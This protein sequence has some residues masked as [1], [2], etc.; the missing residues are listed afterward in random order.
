[1]APD[2]KEILTS[3]KVISAYLGCKTRTGQRWEKELGLPVH[4][5]SDYPRSRVYAYK[6]E[7]DEWIKG[8]IKI[9][10]KNRQKY[11]YFLIPLAA[12]I[13]IYFIWIMPSSSSQPYDFK[14]EGSELVALDKN[15][16]ELWCYDTGH[17]DLE[18]EKFY[19]DHFQAK[20]SSE[21]PG[22]LVS[23][24]LIMIQDI[25]NDNKKEV[26]FIPV[27][28]GSRLGSHLFC[29]SDRGKTKWVFK[30]TREMVFGD[31]SYSGWDIRGFTVVDLFG[32][33]YPEVVL[34]SQ[35]KNMFPSRVAVLDQKG[36]L[37]REYW[38]SG[39]IHEFTF[40][41][42]DEDGQKEILLG[43][44]NNEYNRG[45]LVVL[46]P[47]FKSGASPQTGYY[48]SP[49]LVQ[50]VETQYI[51]FPNTET[52]CLAFMRDPVGRIEIINNK[53]ISAESKSGLYFE[54]DSNYNLKEIR[55][56]DR[57]EDLYQKGHKQGLFENEFSPKV[58][59]E[60]ESQLY[61]ELLYY[62]GDDW[63]TA[64]VMAKN[65]KNQ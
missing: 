2:E 24:P 1:M 31:K 17:R 51:L 13:L 6:H 63:I 33:G 3:W 14:I 11:L 8:K 4:R 55:F 53:I 25:D 61:P 39:R 47:D 12:L 45:C 43:G 62:N 49:T 37:L 21:I 52:A 32:D 7:L 57:Y 64:S 42:L 59:A 36:R 60:L 23:L 56:A 22:E 5:L 20:R 9:E 65:Q 30:Q 29:F 18:E 34:M 35:N 54:F 16:K 48:K 28:T 46:E 50:G 38:N 44:C 40:Y 10:P 27:L 26:M 58:M 41:D 19:R 15:H